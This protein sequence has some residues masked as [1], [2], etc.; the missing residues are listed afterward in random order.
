[1]SELFWAFHTLNARLLA[2]QLLLC[3]LFSF[4][5]PAIN[6][7]VQESTASGGITVN[8]SSI[9]AGGLPLTD[10]SI[11]YSFGHNLTLANGSMIVDD[12]NSTSTTVF[13]LVVG[14]MYMFTLTAESSTGFSTIPCGSILLTVGRNIKSY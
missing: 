3:S 4:S 5:V 9:H 1:M 11:N 2:V 10:L 14:F 12:L 13:D 7:S 6:C 8:W